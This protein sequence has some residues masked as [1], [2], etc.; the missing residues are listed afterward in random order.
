MPNQA[1]H[2][3][4]PGRSTPSHGFFG[5]VILALGLG[6][7]RD[8]DLKKITC[9]DDNG[10]PAGYVCAAN[11]ACVAATAGLDTRGADLGDSGA[12]PSETT[13]PI[14]SSGG[15]ISVVD[16]A[17]A[18][19]GLDVKIDQGGTTAGLDT[20]STGALDASDVA[21]GAGGGSGSGGAPGSGGAGGLDAAYDLSPSVDGNL[22]VPFPGSG[23]LPGTGGVAGAG[24]V[25]GSGGIPGT[26]G[27]A[28]APP[29]ISSFTATPSTVTAGKSV[30]LSWSV[31]GATAI[32]IGGV[33]SVSGS[34]WLVSPT[35]TTTYV[36][37]AQN[38]AGV[39]VIAQAMVTVVA[40]PIITSFTSDATSVLP[41]GSTK[42][43]PVFSGGTGTIDHAIGTVTSGSQYSTGALPAKT[44]YTLTVTN[45]A[46]DSVTAQVTVAVV[47][48]VSGGTM[49]TA[50]TTHTA[51]LLTSGKVLLAG[52]YDGSFT[53][54]QSGEV[55]DETTGTFGAVSNTMSVPRHRHAATLLNSGKVLVS[56]GDY[57]PAVS[58]AD[59]YDPATGTNG[60][61]TQVT[62]AMKAARNN[63]TSTLLGDG[64]V[65]LAGG[66]DA[67]AANTAEIYDPTAGTNGSF[68][69]TGNLNAERYSHTATLLLTGQVLITGG[70]G[71][72]GTLKSAEIY[73]N[74]VFSSIAD[75]NQARD[76]HAAVLLTDGRVLIAGGFD[77]SASLTSAE[78]YDP[79]TGKFSL[80][81]TSLGTDRYEESGTRLTDGTVLIAGGGSGT[82]VLAADLYDPNV[83]VTGALRATAPMLTARVAHTATLLKSGK[84]LIAGGEVTNPTGSVEIFIY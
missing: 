47:G 11:N 52:G 56:G 65:L 69:W 21:L 9:H 64:R 51:T 42:L 59:L 63:H 58:T 35:Q 81:G 24:G 80:L 84:V 62:A 15:G 22:D 5:I 23:G 57:P 36:L 12:G 75:M 77:G 83:G 68:A 18:H 71:S 16:S 82:S 1:L 76:G 3:R 78:I 43:N 38:A 61:F 67:S 45:A 17:E 53:Y 50:R 55:Y 28:V 73:Y 19:P 48:F 34:S 39:S 14:D 25:T 31:T 13:P 20:G 2:R 30:T 46:N 74:G 6:C 27:T 60:K 4:A 70:S 32:A 10:C 54:L 26:G 79:Q 7:F 37:T 72:S 44:L 29:V 40:A 8:P 33:G 49:T 66:A 41:G